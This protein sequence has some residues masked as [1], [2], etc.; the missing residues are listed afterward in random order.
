M[1]FFISNLQ[2]CGI[3]ETL[4]RIREASL[5]GLDYIVLR[6]ND[7]EDD[8]LKAYAQS[9]LQV[10]AHTETELIISHRDY[11]AD[12]LGVKKHNRFKERTKDSFIVSTHSG[13]EIMQVEGYHFFSHIFKTSCK[14]D[15]EPKGIQ[16][17]ERLASPRLVALGGINCETVDDLKSCKHLAVMSEWLTGDVV[18]II[19]TYR[20]KGF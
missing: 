16:L 13:E 3:N 11:I 6:E 5:K 17:L 19:E 9:I 2:I 8:A 18:N 4:R 14:A 7:L 1:I 15:L 10:I 12:L 20:K